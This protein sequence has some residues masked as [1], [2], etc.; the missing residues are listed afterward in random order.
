MRDREGRE[1]ISM[2]RATA[3]NP[4]I[5]MGKACNVTSTPLLFSITFL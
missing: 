4:D 1:T 5:P 2:S 3:K